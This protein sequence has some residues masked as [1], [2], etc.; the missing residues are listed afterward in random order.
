L[1]FRESAFKLLK[2]PLTICKQQAGK[3][4]KQKK[5]MQ[6]KMQTKKQ[7]ATERKQQQQPPFMGSK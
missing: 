5:Q 4:E 3:Y 1:Q 2:L 6:K 7:Q